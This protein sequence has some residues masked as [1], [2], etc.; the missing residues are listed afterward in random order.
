ML[1]IFSIF[2]KKEH[3]MIRVIFFHRSL[4]VAILVG[5]SMTPLLAVPSKTFFVTKS[6]RQNLQI[7]HNVKDALTQKGLDEEASLYKVNKLFEKSANFTAKV[8][9]LSKNPILSLSQESINNA[10]VKYALY[11]KNLN[12][13]SY[14]SLVSFVQNATSQPLNNEQLQYLSSVSSL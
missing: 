5:S 8:S 13:N 14:S 4:L 7:F 10:L 2:K 11:E 1:N 12:L 3:S 6:K 9:L